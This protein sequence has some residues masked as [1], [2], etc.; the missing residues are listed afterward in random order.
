[1]LWL[2][3]AL[4][5]FFGHIVSRILL[6]WMAIGSLLQKLFIDPCSSL[7]STKDQGPR[8]KDQ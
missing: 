1:M 7:R 2:E 5:A 4:L 8:T 6:Q 3:L